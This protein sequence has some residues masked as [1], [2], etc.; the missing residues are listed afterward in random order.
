MDLQTITVKPSTPRIGAE[1]GDIDLTRSLSNR[2]VQDVYEALLK[3]QVIF[4]RDQEIDFEQHTRFAKSFG[5][6]H[7]HV[8]GDGTASQIIP[9]H[10]EIRR[11]HFDASSKRVSGE[12]W[13][14]DQSCAEIPPMGSILYQKVV[15]PDGGGDTLFASMYAAYEALSPQMKAFL[16]PF[17]AIHDGAQ[18][19]DK[20]ATTKY[21][22]AVH[23]VIAKHPDTGR[24]LIFV[25]CG[26]TT[27]INELPIDESDAVLAFLFDHIAKP[28]WQ[29][30][31]RW[32]EHSIAFWD[33]RCT[34]HFAIWDY[35]PHVRSGFRVQVEG[36][37]RPLAA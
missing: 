20:N 37:A 12:V 10:P 16:E 15:P 33:N 18:A 5:R 3:Y 17:T 11:Q 23:P 1:I 2:Q 34:Q 25:N 29:V 26:F 21:P 30:R 7:V 27:R 6:L 32:S 22:V 8:G 9:G 4:F 19:F 36:T 28:H 14:T 35:W 31:F 24:K 13:H